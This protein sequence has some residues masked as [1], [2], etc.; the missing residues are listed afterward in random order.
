MDAF[1]REIS[2]QFSPAWKDSLGIFSSF[3]FFILMRIVSKTAKVTPS[4]VLSLLQLFEPA[5]R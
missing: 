4:V 5:Y 1:S 2:S 3:V